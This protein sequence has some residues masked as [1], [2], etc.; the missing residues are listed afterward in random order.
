MDEYERRYAVLTGVGAV[1][2]AIVCAIYGFKMAGIGGALLGL[3][4]GPLLGGLLAIVF[5]VIF[6]GEVPPAQVF[7]RYGLRACLSSASL[8]EQSSQS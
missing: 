3:I 8:W 2:G 5:S 6:F 7:W 4:L 1:V